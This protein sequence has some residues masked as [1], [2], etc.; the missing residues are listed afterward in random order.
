MHDKKSSAVDVLVSI[1]LAIAAAILILNLLSACGPTP[2]PES[3]NYNWPNDTSLGRNV[4][5]FLLGGSWYIYRAIDIE[6]GNVCYLMT[7]NDTMFCMP[8]PDSYDDGR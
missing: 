7:G 4:D 2:E 8:L 3:A 6:L 5:R 1:V